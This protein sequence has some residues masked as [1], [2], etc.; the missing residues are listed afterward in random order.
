MVITPHRQRGPV[1]DGGC[2]AGDIANDQPAHSG[3]VKSAIDCR[4][5]H[6]VRGA[7]PSTR[8]AARRWQRGRGITSRFRISVASMC[9]ASARYGG[10]GVAALLDNA[11]RR[12]G[13]WA[14][15]LLG[16]LDGM[17]R[18]RTPPPAPARSTPVHG[19]TANRHGRLRARARRRPSAGHTRSF[20]ACLERDIVVVEVARRRCSRRRSLRRCGASVGTRRAAFGVRI[21]PPGVDGDIPLAGLRHFDLGIYPLLVALR[22][23]PGDQFLGLDR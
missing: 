10:R 14:T 23:E 11:P 4:R 7:V 19:A 3:S 22:L 2:I 5:R 9:L 1:Q 20:T 6:I 8:A 21:R 15:G 16:A 17:L 13:S 18:R 12:P